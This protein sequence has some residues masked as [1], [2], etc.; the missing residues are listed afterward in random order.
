MAF[1]IRSLFN[2]D[3]DKPEPRPEPPTPPQN[4]LFKIVEGK[5]TNSGPVSVSSAETSPLTI[6]DMLSV[7]PADCLAE[8][9]PDPFSPLPFSRD[10]IEKA[11]KSGEASLP[12]YEVYM[13][14]PD[15][16]RNAVPIQDT[17]KI[18]LPPDKIVKLLAAGSTAQTT[19]A[20]QPP[21]E[22]IHPPAVQLQ[23][24][25]GHASV[26]SVAEHVDDDEGVT[27]G[28]AGQASPQQADSEGI[29]SPFTL[30]VSP[31]EKINAL[32]R[33]EAQKQ[34]EPAAETA[35]ESTPPPPATNDE[36]VTL[37]LSHAL[38]YCRE[39]EIGID[40]SLLP[41]SVDVSLPMAVIQRQIASGEKPAVKLRE[42]RAGMQNEHKVLL[43]AARPDLSIRL[44]VGAF[45]G[46]QDES[47]SVA[48]PLP[49]VEQGADVVSAKPV[50]PEASAQQ[51]ALPSPPAPDLA[52]SSSEDDP[53][54]EMPLIPDWSMVENTPGG[55]LEDA[56][57]EFPP[58]PGFSETKSKTP[59]PPLAPASSFPPAPSVP[60]AS[61]SAAK[62]MAEESVLPPASQPPVF[63]ARD[64]SSSNT[65][66][67]PASTKRPNK[68]RRMLLRLLLGTSEDLDAEGIVK[69]IL[70][71][72]G[73]LAVGCVYQQR[74]FARAAK[75]MESAETF[76]NHIVPIHQHLLPLVELSGLEG[77]ET[78]TLR[79]EEHLASFALHHGL[80][81]A[82]LHSP[83]QNETELLEKITLLTTELAAMLASEQS[84]A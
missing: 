71:L 47:P 53:F 54:A 16:F 14:C 12:L 68:H 32:G 76:L 45:T 69:T 61:F 5:T 28:N 44:P 65:P 70:T 73:V 37:S 10:T 60:L 18:H 59:S 38:K 31:F 72:P 7:L 51:E 25:G 55:E 2:P 49:S 34:A 48:S 22:A 23:E 75:D 50:E 52:N 24:G 66:A 15:L 27:V 83:G 29:A 39:E 80:T 82:L 74:L 26:F 11:L 4:L 8:V 58:L 21:V 36:K 67:L 63:K 30:A 42:I 3:S 1:S 17:R 81:L 84:S 40:P 79:S 13:A 78:V 56:P 33:N 57:F 46:E 41:D 77:T 9:V 19:A 20:Q 64:S 35:P 43:A 62:K 6:G